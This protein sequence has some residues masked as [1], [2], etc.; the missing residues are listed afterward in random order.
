MLACIIKQPRSKSVGF[1]N[2]EFCL[3]LLLCSS[4]KLWS[5]VMKEVDPELFFSLCHFSRENK[6]NR[7]D[8]VDGNNHQLVYFCLDKK[9]QRHRAMLPLMCTQTPFLQLHTPK[10]IVKP[11]TSNGENNTVTTFLVNSEH[12]YCSKMSIHRSCYSYIV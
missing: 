4:L 6:E 3:Y 9:L 12:E 1:I 5:A 11:A 10:R 2:I 7:G 8:F